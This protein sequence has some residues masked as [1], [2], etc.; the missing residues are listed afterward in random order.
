MYR[1]WNCQTKPKITKLTKDETIR[2]RNEA[3][4]EKPTKEVLKGEL[5]EEEE[6]G[7]LELGTTKM[8]LWN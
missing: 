4:K 7:G 3:R 6:E 2:F 5:L 8:V 1:K